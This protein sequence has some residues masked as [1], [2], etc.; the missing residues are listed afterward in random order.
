MVDDPTMDRAAVVDATTWRAVS[1]PLEFDV[2]RALAL[3]EVFQRELRGFFS[4]RKRRGG[5]KDFEDKY[6]PER[7]TKRPISSTGTDCDGRQTGFDKCSV[8]LL[9]KIR[10]EDKST[11]KPGPIDAGVPC[12]MQ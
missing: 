2:I 8:Q 10:G 1:W 3:V 9:D 4:S 6:N 7:I 12:S 5:S 11:N